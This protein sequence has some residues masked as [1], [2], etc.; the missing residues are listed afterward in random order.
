MKWIEE[1]SRQI[2][3]DVQ[4]VLDSHN[5]EQDIEVCRRNSIRS[6]NDV[7]FWAD[8]FK[9]G[10]KSLGDDKR[11]GRTNT[12]TTD[13]NIAKVHQM[14]LDDH[15]IYS[16]GYEHVKR[17]YLSHIKSTFRDEKDVR[18]LGAPFAHVR[19]KRFES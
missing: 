13:E 6:L 14:V 8:E 7:K 17:T 12:A 10:R 16:R 4:E 3:D 15:L 11:S 19:Q 2:S 18:A 1:V 5:Q 9:R